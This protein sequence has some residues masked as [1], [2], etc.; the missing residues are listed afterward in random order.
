M[1]HQ[2]HPM[3]ATSAKNVNTPAVSPARTFAI[4]GWTRRPMYLTRYVPSSCSPLAF[5][6]QSIPNRSVFFCGGAKL[7]LRGSEVSAN[8]G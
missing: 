7:R 4:N 5:L 2:I 6:R 8:C 3:K 1:R